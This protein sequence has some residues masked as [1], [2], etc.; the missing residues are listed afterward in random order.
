VVIL[1]SSDSA[2]CALLTPRLLSQGCGV[3]VV[4]RA[5]EALRRY[6][7]DRPEFVVLDLGLPRDGAALELLA[8]FRQIDRDVP[9]VA[10]ATRGW[11]A[12]TIVRAMQ[13]G[14]ADVL[15]MPFDADKLDAAIARALTQRQ[16]GREMAT[17]RQQGPSQSK[18]T[19]LFGT[20]NGMVELRDV[21]D[22]VVDTDATVLIRGESG[23]GKELVARALGDSPLRH[24]KQFVKINCAALPSDLLEAELFGFERGAFTGAV[25]GKPGK[26]EIAA[27]GTIF[28]D[29]I[30]EIPVAL[31]SKLLQVLQDGRFSRLGGHEE[32][33]TIARVVAA[34]NRDLDQAV[35]EGQFR[36]DLLFRLNVIPMWVPPLRERRDEIPALAEFFAKRWAVQYN[37][38]YAAVSSTMMDAFLGY[39]WPGNIRELENLIKRTVVFG[40]EALA[41]E[42]L[43]ASA[44]RLATRSPVAVATR[45][46]AASVVEPPA[47]AE[48]PPAI[49]DGLGIDPH[50]LK[51]RS[52]L[53]ASEAEY[54]LMTRMLRQTRGDWTQAARNLG[55]CERTFAYKAK[56]FGIVKGA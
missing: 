13:L 24:G 42:A 18:Y 23:T 21:M 39:S 51:Q 37:R 28:L 1:V 22:R 52:R 20:G 17:L 50:S 5:E 26:F 4:D 3:G 48:G 6:R 29:E 46:P 11:T 32:I 45:S 8:Q 34:T 14:A 9:I 27:G 41:Q 38:R 25:H 40:S 10:V 43:S 12:T 35:L 56:D 31:Q 55:I 16:V 7:G 33:H 30:G 19:M 53:A 49:A 15:T 47:H 44:A 36:D 2:A 54:A